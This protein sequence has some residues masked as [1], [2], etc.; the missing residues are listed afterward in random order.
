MAKDTR[1]IK[2]RWL[3]LPFLFISL[4]FAQTE[5]TEI[6][7][8]GDQSSSARIEA[9][10]LDGSPAIAVVFAGTDDLHYY[11][12]AAGAPAPGLE[13]KI[14]A[15]AEGLTFGEPVFP[16]YHYFAD[17]SKGKIEVFVG[18]FKVLFPIRDCDENI[19]QTAVRI[20][21]AGITCTSKVCLPPFTKTL[22]ATID[23]SQWPVVSIQA[24]EAVT[25]QKTEI[26]PIQPP[27]VKETTAEP[28][29]AVSL[30]DWKTVDAIEKNKSASA[31]WYFLLAVIGGGVNQY[32]AVR[33]AGDS[34][35][36]HAIG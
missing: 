27:P 33:A 19:S 25:E 9:T 5:F 12:T 8:S 21:I 28:A 15:A 36:Y 32:H 35:D 34:A 18:D 20:E 22:T 23:L 29:L 31:A 26:V 14:T 1:I 13:L 4:T 30:A 11:A 7:R 17:P 2:S 16:A 24:G 6:A 3:L 10:E